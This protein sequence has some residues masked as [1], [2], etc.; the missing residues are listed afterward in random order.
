VALVHARGGHEGPA[1][2]AQ[3]SG[4]QGKRNTVADVAGAMD[5]LVRAGV[6]VPGRMAG[7]AA[8]A[9]GVPLLGAAAARPTYM[10]AMVLQSALLDLAGAMAVDCDVP[11]AEACE[12]GDVQSV[13]TELSPLTSLATL[14]AG[15]QLQ[16]RARLRMMLSASP[17]DQRVQPWQVAKFLVTLRTLQH[18]HP[19]LPVDAWLL[20]HADGQRGHLA[21]NVHERMRDAPTECAFLL[22]SLGDSS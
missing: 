10:H 7:W 17:A 16:G 15:L 21:S 9:G 11:L 5:E 2:H 22:W 12:W 20:W 8:S 3:G 18:V 14:C 13:L 1:W 6:T 19:D 4:N